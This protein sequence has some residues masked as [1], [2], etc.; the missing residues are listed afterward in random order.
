MAETP[1]S[2]AQNLAHLPGRPEGSPGRPK[3]VLYVDDNEL[4]RALVT[5]ILKGK[6]IECQTADDGAQGV[7]AAKYGGWDL[8]LMDIQMP[9][10][11]GIEATKRIRALPGPTA[12]IPILALTCHT[13]PENLVLYAEV[14][15]DDCIA[16]PVNIS[17]LLGKVCDWAKVGCDVNEGLVA[18]A[19]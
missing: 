7:E 16:K 5:A 10:M 18:L 3:R 1:F 2:E 8:I 14:G 9:E 11:D 4:N 17:E 6:Q 12:R 15:F 19:S 13:L